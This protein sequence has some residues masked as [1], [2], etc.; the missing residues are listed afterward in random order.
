V[1][2]GILGKKLGMT[3]IF[4]EWG[5][6]I[7][8]TVIEAGPIVVMQVKTPEK[9]GYAALQ[10]GF[11]EKK[12]QRAKKPEV[13]HARKAEAGPKQVIKEVRISP[14]DV[15]NYSAGQ[16][17]GLAD[18]PFGKGDQVD[19]IGKSI[20]KGFAGVMK[21][22]NFSGA[23]ASHGTHEYKRHAGSIGQSA[24]PSRVFKG[25]KMAGQ[26][27]NQRVTVQNLK[28]VDVRPEENLILIRGAVPGHSNGILKIRS[29]KKKKAG[30][31][32]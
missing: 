9:D 31:A 30:Q 23:R 19:I 20:G 13:G 18:M 16:T 11:G 15:E 14:E 12:L 1:I 3:S 6:M 21:R 10:V 32:A 28:I 5:Q 8:V 4:D 26:L 24:A 17:L 25:K 22:H 29:A 2:E 7:P 27:G